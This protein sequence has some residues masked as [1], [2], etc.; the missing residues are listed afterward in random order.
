MIDIHT[1]VLPFVD[2]GST[3]MD[4]SL[5]LLQESVTIGVTDLF[6][7]PHYMK[8]RDY[9]STA[10]EN[11]E[12]FL[13][14]QEEVKKRNIPIRLYLGNEIFY[15]IDSLH[16]LRSGIV[17]P[18]GDS[19]KV[20]LEFST[21]DIHEDIGEAIHN[22]KALGY[23]PIIAHSERYPYIDSLKDYEIMRKMGALIQVNASS[24]VG[25]SGKTMQKMAFKLIKNE[26]VDFIASDIHVSRKNYMKEAYHLVSKKFGDRS[27]SR[28]FMNQSV[29]QTNR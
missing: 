25:I 28:L 12:V 13:Q 9:L 7:T 15:T 18:L 24:V 21:T 17:I 8:T 19:D 23:V 2:D 1:H 27:A 4:L 14:L 20:L 11:R 29:L 6:L 3:A 16:D 10:T 26:L 22:V 5:Q